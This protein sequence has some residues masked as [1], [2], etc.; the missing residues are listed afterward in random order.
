MSIRDYIARFNDLTLCF[1]V[2]EDRCRTISWFCLSLR[3][4]IRRAMLT[5]SYQVDS[6]EEAFHLTLE[7]ELSF[8]GIFIFKAFHLTLELE[9]FFKGIFIFKAMQ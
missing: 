5:S 2:R 3:F 9:L 4:D 6:V 1:D 7:L 8:K